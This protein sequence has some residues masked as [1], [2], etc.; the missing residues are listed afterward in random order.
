MKHR[1]LLLLVIAAL[2]PNGCKGPVSSLLFRPHT[3]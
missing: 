1:M 2:V 3:A